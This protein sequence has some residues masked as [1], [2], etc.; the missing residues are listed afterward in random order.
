MKKYI[1]FFIL[2]LLIVSCK[3]PAKN[4]GKG[5]F[6]TMS[7]SI[8]TI[9]KG[10]ILKKIMES[11]NIQPKSVVQ[12]M[13]KVG[14]KLA[15]FLIKEGDS[16]K[17]GQK[18]A[19]IYPDINEIQR[20]NQIKKNYKIA[21]LD[22]KN[23]EKKYL[24]YKKMIKKGY[25][26]QQDY[27]EVEKN[28]INAKMSYENSK[29]E[30]NYISDVKEE[31]YNNNVVFSIASPASGTF[32]GKAVEVGEFIRSAT[33]NYA[34]GTILGYVGDLSTLE[35]LIN[36]DEVD[37]RY[38]KLDQNS[39]ITFDSVPFFKT[40]GIVSFI[41]LGASVI[42]GFNVF[43]VKVDLTENSHKIKPG[44]S[45]NVDIIIM[46]KEGVLKIPKSAV[47]WD[48]G[49]S[50]VK[51]ENDEIK[52]ITIGKGDDYFFEVKEGLNAGDKVKYIKPK[53]F[54][55]GSFNSKSFHK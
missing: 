13:S 2:L 21:K 34:S 35:V 32:Y 29:L 20:M 39:I 26:S 30:M 12:I 11:G 46:K 38:V 28:Y 53:N 3:K 52:Y 40:K 24:S 44:I 4:I 51:T 17:E 7:E 14:G 8:Y 25:V 9:E 1:I 22:F 23:I 42:G 45:A 18:I 43:S 41:S 10:S 19:L 49:K 47:K 36:L 33:S 37:R 31:T 48:K 55:H 5:K 54:S 16:V 50:F 6:P 27:D 15:K